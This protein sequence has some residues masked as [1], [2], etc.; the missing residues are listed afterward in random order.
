MKI[1]DLIPIEKEKA[2]IIL[3]PYSNKGDEAVKY[4]NGY[5][6]Y[7][8]SNNL[9]K[10]VKKKGFAYKEINCIS[11]DKWWLINNYERDCVVAYYKE[12]FT[13][14]LLLKGK[15]DNYKV[16]VYQPNEELGFYKSYSTFDWYLIPSNA[17]KNPI[18]KYQ[19]E[20]TIVDKEEF[21]KYLK[22]VILN[23]LVG[24]ENE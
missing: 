10:F 12:K 11:I 4:E 20:L 15:K 5:I 23:N 21:G 13:T 19:D 1:I 22:G 8:P 16:F 14:I 17:E 3:N 24:K 18:L 6:D 2:K 9:L 7:S